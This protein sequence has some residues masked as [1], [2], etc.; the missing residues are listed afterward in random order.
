[1]FLVQTETLS[2]ESMREYKTFAEN[3]WVCFASEVYSVSENDS[4]KK[5]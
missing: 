5:R 2:K 3:V 4:R 1:M